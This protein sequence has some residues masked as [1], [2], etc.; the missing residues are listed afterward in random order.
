MRQPQTS[1]LPSTRR[2]SA[3]DRLRLRAN[4]VRLVFSASPWRAAGYLLSYLIVSGLLFSVALA[5]T[6]VTAALAITVALAP[7]LIAAAAVVRSCAEVGRAMLGQVTRPPACRSGY[8]SL[9]GKGLWRRA[10]LIW[11]SGATWRDMAYLVGLW[12]PLYALAAVVVAVWLWLLAGITL[13]L[14]YRH[15]ADVCVGDCGSGNAPGVLIGNYPNGPHGA[16]ASGLWIYP[17]LGPALLLALGCLVAFLLF[18]Y[19]LIAAARLHA[20]VSWALLRGQPDPLES[21]RAVLAKP[22]PLGPLVRPP[23]LPPAS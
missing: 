4:P 8:P 15:V 21:A 18:N 14:W 22:G 16:G 11:A 1:V 19:V 12:I 9:T 20:R 5:A 17:S 2:P 23:G 10:R 13:P 6:T 7:L 3:T